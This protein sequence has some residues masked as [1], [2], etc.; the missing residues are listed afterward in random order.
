VIRRARVGDNSL[1]VIVQQ[2][3]E[4]FLSLMQRVVAMQESLSLGKVALFLER[5]KVLEK[6]KRVKVRLVQA[7]GGALSISAASKTVSLCDSTTG[8]VVVA[9]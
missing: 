5:E 4:R 1:I 8:F 6:A 3:R 9:A 7:W 2:K